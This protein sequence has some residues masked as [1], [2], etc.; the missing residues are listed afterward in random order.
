M[1]KIKNKYT[2]KI[3]TVTDEQLKQL[4]DANFPFTMVE[5]SKPKKPNVLMETEKKI[6]DYL[7]EEVK[8]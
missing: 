1:P 2:G 8:E 6:K 4:K 5:D 7:N 3:L